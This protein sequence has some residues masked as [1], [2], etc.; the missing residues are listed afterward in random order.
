MIANPPIKHTYVLVIDADTM[1]RARACPTT[2]AALITL[3]LLHGGRLV[4]RPDGSRY[5]SIQKPAG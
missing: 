2:F 5:A 4:T 1:E 3:V